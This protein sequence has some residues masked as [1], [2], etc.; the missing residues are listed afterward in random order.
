MNSEESSSVYRNSWDRNYMPPNNK[1]LPQIPSLTPNQKKCANQAESVRNVT[2][3]QFLFQENEIPNNPDYYSNSSIYSQN[4]IHNEEEQYEND[5]NNET[6]EELPQFHVQNMSEN[7]SEIPSPPLS[8]RYHHGTQRGDPGETPYPDINKHFLFDT[9]LYDKNQVI[10]TQPNQQIT[11]NTPSEGLPS[12]PTVI[13][14][15]V[16]NS[17]TT[18]ITNN[19]TTTIIQQEKEKEKNDYFDQQVKQILLENWL[20]DKE[21]QVLSTQFIVARDSVEQALQLSNEKGDYN[22]LLTFLSQYIPPS[23]PPP[24]LPSKSKPVLIPSYD[25]NYTKNIYLPNQLNPSQNTIPPA[26]IGPPP[27]PTN[28]PVILPSLFPAK[29]LPA[30][31]VAVATQ[32]HPIK[33]VCIP[34]ACDNQPI[35]VNAIPIATEII[36]VNNVSVFQKDE[37]IIERDRERDRKREEREEKREIERRRREEEREKREYERKEREEERRRERRDCCEKQEI[38]STMYIA[39]N[40]RNEQLVVCQPSV[41]SVVYINQLTVNSN[42]P[43]VFIYNNSLCG[44]I[45]KYSTPIKQIKGISREI[46]GGISRYVFSVME[47]LSTNIYTG[48]HIPFVSVGMATPLKAALTLGSKNE[49]VVVELRN[50]LINLYGGSMY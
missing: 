33:D 26:A 17:S 8:S 47:P 11:E 37:V 20:T 45:E 1:P 19:Y 39:Q 43:I 38:Q 42:P 13:S 5:E 27:V 31:P 48:I 49:I 34:E 22:Y 41:Q 3:Q 18:T 29:S 44:Y 12:I 40:N 4:M 28:K 32:Y 6:I 21:K 25:A 23:P 35:P 2:D 46:D 50:R 24:P 10:K 36:P 16:E 14:S 15:N 30:V 7:N 9:N